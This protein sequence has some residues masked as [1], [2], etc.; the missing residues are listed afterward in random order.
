VEKFES[1]GAETVDSYDEFVF[2]RHFR[3]LRAEG[4]EGDI[5]CSQGRLNFGI[6]TSFDV[7]S[8]VSRPPLGCYRCNQPS[9]VRA[10]CS[11]PPKACYAC[12][13]ITHYV[14]NC[15]PRA[16]FC[17]ETSSLQQF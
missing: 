10:R 7:Q 9:H 1:L 6:Y 4:T 11:T 17:R 3:E 14:R 5:S 8:T 15:P 16:K 13:E 12:G 2:I